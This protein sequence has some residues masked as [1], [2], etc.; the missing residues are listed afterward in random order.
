[1]TSEQSPYRPPAEVS[2]D[3]DGGYSSDAD[4]LLDVATRQRHV[5]L[6]VLAYLGLVGALIAT[7][8]AGL[9]HSAIAVTFGVAAVAILVCGAITVYRLAAIFRGKVIAVIY[10]VGAMVPCLGLLLLFSVSQKATAALQSHGIK[11]GLLG[12]NPASIRPAD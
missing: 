11:V 2:D 3:W 9:L 12:A 6:V 8:A 1:M 10:V 7:N 4:Y 5:A